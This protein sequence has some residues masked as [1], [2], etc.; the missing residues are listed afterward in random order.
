M[1]MYVSV[2]GG[3]HLQYGRVGQNAVWSQWVGGFKGRQRRE[4]REARPSLVRGV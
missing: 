4:E 1:C 2:T 3:D